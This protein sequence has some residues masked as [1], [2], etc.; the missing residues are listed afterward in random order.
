M[1]HSQHNS[2]C[3]NT[4]DSTISPNISP[5][6]PEIVS[7]VSP[8][9]VSSKS[10]SLTTSPKKPQYYLNSPMSHQTADLDEHKINGGNGSVTSI[11]RIGL[12][13]NKRKYH[14]GSGPM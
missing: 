3:S 10:N 13:Y 9:S 6:R 12:S 1:L 5:K 7:R 11:S 4:S 8:K 2:R 14:N